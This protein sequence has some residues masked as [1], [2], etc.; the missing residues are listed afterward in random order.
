MLDFAVARIEEESNNKKETRM[1]TT[2]TV[3]K[4]LIPLE[5]IALIEPFDSS[6]PLPLPTERSFQARVVLLDRDS[7]LT[8]EA[9]AVFPEK[10][11]FRLLT[12]DGIATNPAIHFSV[13]EFVPAEGFKP[14]K[15]YRSRLMW[16]DLNGEKQSKLLLSPPATV[17]AIAV[18]GEP[19]EAPNPA[20]QAKPMRRP[21]RRASAPTPA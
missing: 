18:R 2:V 21:R 6:T 7:V 4:R 3:G 16:R 1:N 5:Q 12:E 14:T 17:L 13:E 10:Y 9:L 8:E 15:P 11:G 19:E 20:A